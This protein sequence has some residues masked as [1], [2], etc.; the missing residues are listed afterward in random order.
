MPDTQSSNTQNSAFSSRSDDY[1]DATLKD[2]NESLKS[3]QDSLYTAAKAM[4]LHA[5]LRKAQNAMKADEKDGLVVQDTLR[6]R[7]QEAENKLNHQEQRPMDPNDPGVNK[8]RKHFTQER[9][10]SG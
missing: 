5:S 8:H 6:K 9:R 2:F 7:W 10:G 3:I 4:S 1:S